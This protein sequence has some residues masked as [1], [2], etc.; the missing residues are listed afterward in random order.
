M[1]STPKRPDRCW[2]LWGEKEEEFYIGEEEEPTYNPASTASR[3]SAGAMGSAAT[4]A[5]SCSRIK[6]RPAGSQEE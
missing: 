6:S 1:Q 4:C 3:I 2:R 5:R